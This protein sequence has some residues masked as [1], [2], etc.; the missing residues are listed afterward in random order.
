MQPVLLGMRIMDDP[1]DGRVDPVRKWSV[2]VRL[3]S[4]QKPRTLLERLI[5]GARM[6]KSKPIGWITAVTLGVRRGRGD[7]MPAQ[8]RL[9]PGQR[10]GDGR[11]QE[12]F[13]RRPEPSPLPEVVPVWPPASETKP[14]GTLAPALP[15]ESTPPPPALR[16]AVVPPTC[17]KRPVSPQQL[18]WK[19]LRLLTRA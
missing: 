14:E 1:L 9:S 18:L 17:R 11:R 16:A 15:V 10:P 4:T 19:H 12:G 8:G 3:D 5:Q 6:F 2:N 13:R 7:C